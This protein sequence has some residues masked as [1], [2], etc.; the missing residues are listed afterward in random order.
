MTELIR[1]KQGEYSLESSIP[2]ESVTEETP[3]KTLEDLF[4]YPKVEITEEQKGLVENG[5]S[6]SLNTT[7]EKVFLT[8]QEKVIAIYERKDSQYKMVFKVI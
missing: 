3:L 7:E 8:F 5:N 1:T 2:L 4:S 6:L